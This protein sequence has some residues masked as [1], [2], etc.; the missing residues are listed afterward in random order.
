MKK[1]TVFYLVDLIW[2]IVFGVLSFIE[3]KSTDV[4][5]EALEGLG[6]FYVYFVLCI[7]GVVELIVMLLVNFIKSRK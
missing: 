2:I 7:L 6:R 1:R 3:N 4:G 5:L